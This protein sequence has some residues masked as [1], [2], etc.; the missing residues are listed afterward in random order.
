MRSV[1]KGD[2]PKDAAGQ[3]V[4]FEKYT[5]AAPYLFL[6]IGRYCSYCERGMPT[7][8]AV[9]HKLPKSPKHYPH[10]ELAWSNFL[11][12]CANCNSSK[13]TAEFSGVLA[14]WPD[15]EDTYSLI[16][17]RE[18]GAV[19]PR[20]GLAFPQ[21]ARAAALIRLVGL[22][23]TPQTSSATDHRFFDRL[24]VLSIAKQAVRDLAESD[25]SAMRSTIVNSAKGHGGYSIWRAVFGGD[26]DM[27]SR[28]TE[29]FVGTR[30]W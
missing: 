23:K 12:A 6:R 29:A 10:L 21:A 15:E 7:C 22:D 1:Y 17:Y 14:L 13:G 24:E 8:L 26:V 5:D 9:E 27:Q 20:Q 18:S 2:P 3:D 25:T 11:L 30:L 28:L 19:A 4:A 16:E